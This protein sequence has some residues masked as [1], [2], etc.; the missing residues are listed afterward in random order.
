MKHLH[1]DQF[2]VMTAPYLHH[3]L[4][5]A[6]DSIAANGFKN[7]EL[8]GASPH[9]CIDDYS[10]SERAL[11][12]QKINRMLAGRGLKMP[13]F[14]PEQIRQYPINIASPEKY[15][16]GQSID[17]MKAYLADTAAFGAEKMVVCPGW[18]YVDS[19]ETDDFKRSAESL[20]ILAERAEKLNITMVME[21]IDATR[22]L[23][24]KDIRGL[25]RLIKAVDSPRLQSCADLPYIC[26]HGETIED[27]YETFGEIGHVHAADFGK[28]GYMALGEGESDVFAQ[29]AKLAEHDYDG[30]ISLFMNGAVHYCDPDT[31]IRQSLAWLDQ[32]NVVRK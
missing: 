9:Y 17:A 2:S 8:W 7:V 3:T 24:I 18:P 14:H 31:P 4:E 23:F 28:D 25:S 32:C 30:Q 16:R 1:F 15:I 22:S 13:V 26:G 29:L 21:E 27:Y 20:G 5:Y 6:L 19:Y 10:S 12:I 11:R